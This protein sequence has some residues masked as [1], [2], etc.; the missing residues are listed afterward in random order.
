MNFEQLFISDEN[1]I[2]EMS[3]MATEILRDYYDPLVGKVQN[4]YMLNKFQSQAAIRDQLD[5]DYQY[6]FACKDGRRVGFFAF[7]S[8]SSCLYLSKIYLYKTER[9]KGY[10]GK[11]LDFIITKA[12]EESLPAIELNVNKYNSL[13]IAAYEKRGFKIVRSEK[14]DIGG[15][16]YMDD[17]VYRLE[18]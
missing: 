16:F 9:R 11:I 10:F 6:Y 15:G 7:Y 18:I 4:D 17:Y 3:Q 14:N 13:A 5:Q 1:K 8:K 12:R 2:T